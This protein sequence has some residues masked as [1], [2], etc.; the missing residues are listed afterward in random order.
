MLYV[1]YSSKYVG[2][3]CTPLLYGGYPLKQQWKS[4]PTLA[5]SE[6]D[7]VQ[8][9]LF[10]RVVYVC[11]SLVFVTVCHPLRL[12]QAYVCAVNRFWHKEHFKCFICK[13]H[14][15]TEEGFNYE[16]GHLYC[17]GKGRG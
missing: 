13:R 4:P 12:F 5:G 8:C 2:I 9:V 11:P 3:E 6:S 1:M 14:L 15:G 17:T 7:P 10:S 16:G